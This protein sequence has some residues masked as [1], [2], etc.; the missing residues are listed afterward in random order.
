MLTIYSIIICGT[1]A[2]RKAEFP[3]VPFVGILDSRAISTGI[4]LLSSC[5]LAIVL[6]RLGHI[7]TD[8]FH[9]RLATWS[10]LL[11]YRAFVRFDSD[12][13]APNHNALYSYK[14]WPRLFPFGYLL[15]PWYQ[16]NIEPWFQSRINN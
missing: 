10:Y 15:L 2:V 8:H 4:G 5:L 3:V 14:S 11:T 1:P 12:R 16:R 9:N 6:Y 13:I 7:A